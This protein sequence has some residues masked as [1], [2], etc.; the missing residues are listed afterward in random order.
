MT[1]VLVALSLVCFLSFL[2]P[3]LVLLPAPPPPCCPPKRGQSPVVAPKV[4]QEDELLNCQGCGMYGMT[5]EFLD[6]ETCSLVCQGR[7]RLKI[8]DQAKKER[9]LLVQKHRRE[10]KRKEREKEK[11]EEREKLKKALKEVR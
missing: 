6:L 7:I 8:R 3:Q 10:A 2:L 5:G 9:E 4:A 11:K 1:N